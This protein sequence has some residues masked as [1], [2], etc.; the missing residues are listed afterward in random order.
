MQ[1][2]IGNHFCSIDCRIHILVLLCYDILSRCTTKRPNYKV[3]AATN[4]TATTKKFIDWFQYWRPCAH[5]QR[6]HSV[7]RTTRAPKQKHLHHTVSAKLKKKKTKKKSTAYCNFRILI[8][9]LESGI[10]I[11]Y[12]IFFL[13]LLNSVR[14]VCVSIFVLPHNW[15]TWFS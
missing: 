12:D 14:F 4:A 9:F 1:K 6:G 13:P 11:H 8:F 15:S 2:F 5:I 10:W 7:S 3:T